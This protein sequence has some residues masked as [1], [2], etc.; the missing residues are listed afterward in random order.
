M[1]HDKENL[2]PKELIDC[3]IQQQQTNFKSRLKAKKMK[4]NAL[5]SFKNHYSTSNESQS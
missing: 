3:E 5:D 2:T 4:K 1:N